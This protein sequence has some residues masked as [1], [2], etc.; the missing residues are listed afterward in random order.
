[1]IKPPVIIDEIVIEDD[2]TV[3]IIIE[4]DE[5]VDIIIEEQEIEE[6]EQPRTRTLSIFSRISRVIRIIFA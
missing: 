4:D 2:E 1:M 6:L 5:T 3:D